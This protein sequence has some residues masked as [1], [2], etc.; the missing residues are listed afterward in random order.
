[1][2][3]IFVKPFNKRP[4]VF[5]RVQ[6]RLHLLRQQKYAC[7]YVTFSSLIFLILKRPHHTKRLAPFIFS[8][9]CKI[10]IFAPLFFWSLDEGTGNLVIIQKTKEKYMKFVYG[11]VTLLTFDISLPSS[12]MK[13]EKLKTMF[14]M[15]RFL[16]TN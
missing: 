10:F 15:L 8:Q 11:I 14:W 1:M 5:F 4:K 2:S 6:L 3:L 7:F 16:V 13:N 12:C 9:F